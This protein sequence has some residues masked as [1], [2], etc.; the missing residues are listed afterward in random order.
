MIDTLA[1]ALGMPPEAPEFWL[2]LSFMAL[3]YLVVLAG[4]VL[5]GFDIGVGCL[6]TFAP[7]HLKPRMLALLSPWRDA[8]EFWLFIGLGLFMAAFPLAWSRVMAQLYLPITLLAVGTCLRS[9][10]YELRLRAPRE[11]H[12]F[13]ALVF[14]GGALLTAFSHGLLLAQLAMLSQNETVQIG[15]SLFTAGCAV[16]AYSL[17]GASWLIMRQGGEL[18]ARAIFW[19]R[20]CVR[21]A[22]AGAV[23]VSVVLALGNPGIF[24]KWSSNGGRV[25]VISLWCFM[26]LAFVFIEMCLQRMINTSLRN[27]ALPFV[28][29]LL[30]FIMTFAGLAYSFFPYLVLDELTLW[31]AAAATDSLERV[32]VLVVLALPVALVFNARVYWRMF[33]MSLPPEPPE[34]SR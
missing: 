14:G 29:T 32:L 28:L 27:T 24:L 6:S 3:L 10:G 9:V 7:A 5:D 8:N 16:A 34:F 13:W 15:F 17:L 26:L 11:L 33:G 30:V 22:A 31:D 4:T 25:A 2:P 21:W 19:G 23:G 1:M 20:R 18:R 12:G